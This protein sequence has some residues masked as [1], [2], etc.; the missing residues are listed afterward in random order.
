M[1][2]L[3]LLSIL[4]LCFVMLFAFSCKKDSDKSENKQEQ[5]TST[6]STKDS[7]TPKKDNTVAEKEVKL[8]DEEQKKLNIFFSNFS[9]VSLNPFT[10]GNITDDELI[11]F[12]VWHNQKNNRK[13]FEKAGQDEIKLKEDA[14]S[15]SIQKYFGKNFTAHKAT[16][17]FKYKSGYYF[18]PDGDGEAFTFSQV[19]KVS[20]IGGDRYIA[21]VNVYT[22][23]SGWTGDVHANP[24]SWNANS[25]DKPELTEKFKATFSKTNGANGESIYT[26]I[27]YIKQ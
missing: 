17:D 11:K 25:D 5:K 22:A 23:S 4:L 1:K 21:Y 7:I 14:V 18:T 8:T 19:E 2:K 20:D 27:D 16:P 26:L 15:K 12:G 24:K 6:N 10:A 3:N 13:L 9:E